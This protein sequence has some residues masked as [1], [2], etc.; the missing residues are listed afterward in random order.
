[1]AVCRPL[2]FKTCFP[3]SRVRFLILLIC[4][5]AAL[6]TAPRYLERECVH[7]RNSTRNSSTTQQQ[8]VQG[9]C[10]WQS[11]QSAQSAA[12]AY[13]YGVAAYSLFVFLLPVGTVLVL[14]GHIIYELRKDEMA[15]LSIIQKYERR[16]SKVPLA[17]AVVFCVLQTPA[18]LINVLEFGGVGGALRLRRSLWR[19]VLA[20]TSLLTLTDSA[21]DCAVYFY[22]LNCSCRSLR[23][24]V[25]VPARRRSRAALKTVTTSSISNDVRLNEMTKKKI[26]LVYSSSHKR[27][28]VQDSK[29]TRAEFFS[30]PS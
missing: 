9:L 15:G 23:R 8:Q 4:I 20:L 10:D 11:T 19:T 5:S 25:R 12:Y 30:F 17:I 6:F 3:R 18:L 24:A 14:N 26:M 22:H 2:K 7:T 28:T 16:I 29:V 27:L 1:M 13:G 21:A